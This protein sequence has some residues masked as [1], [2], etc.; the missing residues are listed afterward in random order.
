MGHLIDGMRKMYADD[1]ALLEQGIL[2]FEA[3]ARSFGAPSTKTVR[4]ARTPRQ[5]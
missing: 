5:R 1:R 2:L 3:L 4:R